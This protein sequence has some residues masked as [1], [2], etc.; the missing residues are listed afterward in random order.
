MS[1][2]I[3]GILPG[4]GDDAVALP[5]Y[6]VNLRRARPSRVPIPDQDVV[7]EETIAA[8]EPWLVQPAACRVVW[9]GDVPTSPRETVCLRFA[10]LDEARTQLT[11]VGLWPAHMG[12]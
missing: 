5:G 11:A 3:I 1:I 12:G 7:S 9:A 8:L 10:D 6:H 4:R 2:D